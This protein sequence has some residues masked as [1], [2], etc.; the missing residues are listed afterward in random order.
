M[1]QR[2]RDKVVEGH[3]ASTLAEVRFEPRKSEEEDCGENY[4]KWLIAFGS[5]TWG[6]KRRVTKMNERSF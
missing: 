6:P 4:I 3:R 2:E 5:T 1:Q